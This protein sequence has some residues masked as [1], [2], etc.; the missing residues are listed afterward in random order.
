M[1]EDPSFYNGESKAEINNPFK[2]EDPRAAY[3]GMERRIVI[4]RV[5]QDR[6][7]DV[8]FELDNGDR[9]KNEGRRESDATPKY[10]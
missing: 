4:R 5:A 6:R 8:R 3:L 1:A 10:F 9:R 2:S 7:G